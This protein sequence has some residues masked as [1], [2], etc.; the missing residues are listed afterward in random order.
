MLNL[1]CTKS[2]FS[3]R[4]IRICGPEII[5]LI[6]KPFPGLVWWDMPTIPARSRGETEF[7]PSL[8]YIIRACLFFSFL[9]KGLVEGYQR[10]RALADLPGHRSIPRYH[11]TVHNSL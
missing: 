2:T 8:G 7:E 9:K 10:L 5:L 4:I 11:I 1:T 3:D 6:K